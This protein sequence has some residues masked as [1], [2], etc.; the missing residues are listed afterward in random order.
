MHAMIFRLHFHET[1]VPVIE[2]ALSEGDSHRQA[3]VGR[4]AIALSPAWRG[5]FPTLM[6][7]MMSLDTDGKHAQAGEEDAPE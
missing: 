1:V 2:V 7:Y 6:K 4:N 5:S 3:M